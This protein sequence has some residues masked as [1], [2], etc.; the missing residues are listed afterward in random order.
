MIAVHIFIHFEDAIIAEYADSVSVIIAVRIQ[1]TER[2]MDMM[3]IFAYVIIVIR[4]RY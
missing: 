2:S 1:S 4:H 3:D